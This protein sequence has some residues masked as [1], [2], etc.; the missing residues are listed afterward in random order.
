MSSVIHNGLS[1]RRDV[2]LAR[3][4]KE[5]KVAYQKK[6]NQEPIVLK[7][8]EMKRVWKCKTLP[9][10]P[11]QEVDVHLLVGSVSCSPLT[12]INANDSSVRPS[13]GMSS[14]EDA[15]IGDGTVA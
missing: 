13:I 3:G 9:P 14:Y 6:D 15:A 12:G 10:P 1:H 7:D 2:V 5:G 8:K 11:A 4:G